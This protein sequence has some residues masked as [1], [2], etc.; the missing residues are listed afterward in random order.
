[1]ELFCSVGP[2]WFC[3]FS[4]QS[5]QLL[6]LP[7]LLYFIDFAFKLFF[8]W[9]FVY[10]IEWKKAS[11]CPGWK[12][13][14]HWSR[15]WTGWFETRSSLSPTSTTYS[16]QASTQRVSET[17]TDRWAFLGKTYRQGVETTPPVSSPDGTAATRTRQAPWGVLAE[18]IKRGGKRSSKLV[19]V[20]TSSTTR[21]CNPKS[22]TTSCSRRSLWWRTTS[23]TQKN[24]AKRKRIKCVKNFGPVLYKS[25]S[26]SLNDLR[27]SLKK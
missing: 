5:S 11:P 17:R 19:S 8:H 21:S 25:I 18:R 2:S 13:Q 27:K 26:A 1:M 12:R 23:R 15:K 24:A 20:L 6:I 16:N 10:C 9:I 14:G 4:G 7:E 22:R 3:P